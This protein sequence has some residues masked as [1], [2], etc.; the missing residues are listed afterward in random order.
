[1]CGGIRQSEISKRAYPTT[2][3]R[4]DLRPEDAFPTSPSSP[5]P[6]VWVAVPERD[7]LQSRCQIK[8]A[9][10]RRKAM[11]SRSNDQ[12]FAILVLATNCGH[13]IAPERFAS[14]IEMVPPGSASGT[15]DHRGSQAR[16]SS[17]R[18]GTAKHRAAKAWALGGQP[19]IFI[20]RI[21]DR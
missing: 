5:T 17:R 18:S 8:A 3:E 6:K 20:A 11:M 19:T 2:V 1:M 9:D 14:F 4:A 7:G 13:D 21:F 15:G 16:P 10:G 12:S